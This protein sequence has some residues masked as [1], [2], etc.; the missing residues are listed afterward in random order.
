MTFRGIILSGQT[1]KSE[2]R[3]GAAEQQEVRQKHLTK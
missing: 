3:R 2:V 1:G